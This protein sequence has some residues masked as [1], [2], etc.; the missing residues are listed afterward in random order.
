MRV[1]TSSLH[2]GDGHYMAYVGP[3]AQFDFMAATQFRLLCALGLR[4]HHQLLDFGCGSL[5]A[6]RLFIPYLNPGGYFGIEPNAWLIQDAIHEQLGD[7]IVRIKK[8]TFSYNADFKTNVFAT[9]FDFILTQSIF[10]HA[11]RGIVAT[12]L[13]NFSDSLTRY[14][15]VAATFIEGPTDFIGDGWVYPD[16]VSYRRSTIRGFIED[17]GLFGT[18][19]PWYHPRQSWYVLARTRERLPNRAMMPFLAGAVMFDPEFTASWNVT[20]PTMIK[21]WVTWAVPPPFSN[22]VKRLSNR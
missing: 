9:K 18:R 14:G 16:C 4:A 13:R 11:D 8:P 15:L 5:R 7:D 12:A 17:A 21:N 6:G 2:A 22:L 1:D 3:P 10:S 19:I 20:N